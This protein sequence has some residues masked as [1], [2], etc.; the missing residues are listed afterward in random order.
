MIILSDS[1]DLIFNSRDLNRV[2]KSPLKKPAY[3][4]SWRKQAEIGARK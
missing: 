4:G 1:K 3:T 2:P